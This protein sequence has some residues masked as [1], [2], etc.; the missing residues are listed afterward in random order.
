MIIIIIIIII[1]SIIT[2]I[3]NY[4][5]CPL[6]YAI[7]PGGVGKELPYLALTD[8]CCS[9]GHGFQGLAS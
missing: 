9:T 1:S 2:I 5:T 6:Y 7:P 8:T 4:V 3:R